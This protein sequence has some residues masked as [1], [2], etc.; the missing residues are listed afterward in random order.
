MNKT[1]LYFFLTLLFSLNAFHLRSDIPDSTE[2]QSFLDGVIEAYMDENNVAGAVVSV[3]HN[4]NILVEKGYGY[5]GI[6][7]GIPVNPETTLFRVASITKLFTWLSVMK[8]AEEEM[9]DLDQDVN[10]YLSDFQIPGG[11]DQPV[12]L[13]SLMSHSAGF[14]D[15]LYKLFVSDPSRFKPMGELL[16][17][18]LPERVRPPLKHAS[19]SNHGT[20]V[21]QYVVEQVT[22]MPFERYAEEYIFQP[23][24]MN[25]TTLEQ[26]LPERLADNLSNGYTFSSGSFNEMFFEYIPMKGVGGASSSASD[27]AVFIKALLEGTCRDEYCL[28][29]SVSYTKMKEPVLTHSG[30]MNPALHGFIDMSRNDV[31]I[32]GHGGATFWFHSVLAILPEHDLGLFV[33]FNSAGGSGL[34]VKV[35]YKITD[36]YF[37]D[38]RPLFETINLAEE[39]L[40]QFTGRYVSNRRSHSAFFKVRAVENITD[41]SAADSKL[42]MDEPGGKTSFWLPVDEVTFRKED[43]NELIAFSIEDEKASHMF[44]E[45]LPAVAFERLT[46]F[47]SL[48]L[49]RLVFI[50]TLIS[51]VYILAGWPALYFARLRYKPVRRGMKRLPVEAKLAAWLC[52]ACFAATFILLNSAFGSGRELILELPASM[53]AGLIFPFISILLLLFMIWR[54]MDMWK[55]RR[56]SFRNKLFYTVVII[57]FG[58][59][60]WQLYYWNLL[61]W[62]Y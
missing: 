16:R 57:I 43:S 21:A 49:H 12:T 52:S 46:G 45:Q 1:V 37:P 32:I 54:S 42:R 47:N 28:L 50:A 15:R 39:K 27:M 62:N 55:I 44:R 59:Q 20:G 9:V 6:E 26:P 14:E 48:F 33:S 53:K 60:L 24:G 10:I 34:P 41:I 19:Y 36:R 51:I 38:E 29:D 4:G 35:L 11:F 2:L 58:A 13:R 30:G 40:E 56:L 5:A 3:V 23:L 18:Q 17:E 8:L 22:G 7:R 25:Y 31:K 61:G